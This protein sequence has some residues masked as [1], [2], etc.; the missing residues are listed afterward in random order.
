MSSQGARER[1]EREKALGRGRQPAARGSHV[2]LATFSCGPSYDLV[3]SQCEKGKKNS[4]TEENIDTISKRR[5][6]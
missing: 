3:I 4:A 5:G 2:A 1:A 6:K